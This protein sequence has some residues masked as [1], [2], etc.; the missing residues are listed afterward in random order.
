[1]LAYL[2]LDIIIVIGFLLVG[3]VVIAKDSKAKL[4]RLFLGFV[5][6]IS[7][8]LLANYF[9]NNFSI[10][11]GLAL[12][13]N[14]L[15]LFI[16]GVVMLFLLDFSLTFAGNKKLSRKWLAFFSYSLFVYSLSLTS[17]MFTSI[18][19]QGSVYAIDF[20]SLGGLYFLTL[21]LNM[22]VLI[23]VLVNGRKQT[24]GQ[25][26]NSLTAILWAIVALLSVNV[27][28]NALLPA[29]GGAFAL[30]N[31][32]PISAVFVVA[33]LWYSIVRHHL[34]DIRLIIARS[35]AYAS[36]LF[37][38]VLLFTI[39]SYAMSNIL[40]HQLSA[41]SIKLVYTVL[42]VVLA[43]LFT[44]LK[45]FFDKVTNTFFFRDAYDPQAFLDELNK[46][47]IDNIEIGILLRH[48]AKVI[49]ENLKCEKVVFSLY[50]D[51]NKGRFI[52][53]SGPSAPWK[54]M[55]RIRHGLQK[56]KR[57]IVVRDSL[58]RDTNGLKSLLG[59]NNIAL[60]AS[61]KAGQDD[62]SIAHA[63]LALGE[64]KTGNSFNSQDLRILEIIVNEL[65]IA[66]QN[67]LRFEEI[68]DFNI[69]LQ[70][71]IDDAT[72]KLRRANEK[73]KALD[74]TK[75]DFISMAS[76][77][78]RTPLTS[79]KGY[80]SMVLEEDAGKLTKLQR[81]MLG[82]AFFSSQRMVY[83]IAD[84]LNVS[85]LKTG[86]FII[87]T[88]PVN[89]ADV[90]EQELSQLQETA[91][92][93]NLKLFYDKP[94]NFP[95]VL[96]DETKTRQVIMNFADNAIYYT[97]AGGE[98][99]VRL[100]DSPSTVEL[101]IEDNGIGVPKSEQPHLFTKFYRA[102]NARKARPDGTGLGLFMAK[103]VIASQGGSIIFDSHEDKGST[104][105]FVFSKSKVAVKAD[106]TPETTKS[107]SK[108]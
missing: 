90:V 100:I 27:A 15:T 96:L 70:Q 17:W 10:E 68:Q 46:T 69:T 33:A 102:G 99:H 67:A 87:E 75:D 108:V 54:E 106:P 85:R 38:L 53:A 19:K 8:W 107:H 58:S 50:D 92:A 26:R 7:A 9:S 16:P 81:E 57:Q 20:K 103:K 45:R 12:V 11:Y 59:K 24:T 35:L 91:A 98:I 25:R 78:L 3:F 93:R 88:A 2:V 22:A 29:L 23:V 32:G 77:Q 71:R 4:N 64:K 60:I 39:A 52:D 6:T 83:L 66:V 31:I 65:I 37:I 63:Y 61:L 56:I 95:D 14:H 80:I 73:L 18:H 5:V 41:A 42:A 104:F 86:K 51:L 13:A 34:F 36:S 1:M 28:T 72:H 89:L 40:F 55:D 21:L 97:P 49:E 44:P 101:R 43:L 79:V 62:G 84:L 48:T 94:K 30:T 105:G 74:E 76:H 82:Q 47:L